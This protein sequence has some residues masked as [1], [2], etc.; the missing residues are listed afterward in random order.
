M[1]KR[2]FYDFQFE[3]NFSNNTINIQVISLGIVDKR[4]NKLYLI[5]SD[6]NWNNCT[7]KWLI[8]N[9]KNKLQN[10]ISQKI[11]FKEFKKYILD[12]VNYKEGE[13]IELYGYYS[14]YDH[15]CLASCFGKMIDFPQFFPMFTIDLKQE[16]KQKN[17]TEEIVNTL[18]ENNNNQHNALS[19]A[20]FNYQLFNLIKQMN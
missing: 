7:N 2:L 4:K 12:F 3:E 14:D 9:V 6:Y 15:V 18:I 16:M 1:I 11:K 17:I 5:N 19:D 10:P 20:Q 8:N 13:E